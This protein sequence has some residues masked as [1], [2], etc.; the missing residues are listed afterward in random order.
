MRFPNS[1]VRAA[2]FASAILI[3]F[4]STAI[5]QDAVMKLVPGGE[6][7]RGRTHEWPDKDLPWYPNPLKDDTPVKRIRVDSFL[8]DEAE[9]SNARYAGFLAATQRKPPFHWIK[10][11]VAKGEENHPVVNVSWD[12]AAAFCAWD[13]KRLPT[14]AEW[15]HA[16]RGK[17]DDKK[18]PWGDEDP[19]EE[20]ARFGSQEGGPIAVCSKTRN[21]FELC[22]MIGNAWEWTSD[23]YG[24]EYYADAPAE[25]P[26]GPE[27][28]RYRVVRGGSWFDKTA[29]QFLTCS[30]RSWTRQTERSPNIG[31]RCVKA[32]PAE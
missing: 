21:D 28:G 2:L 15:E 18:Y 27:L 30:Y 19:S 11:H 10:G 9:V 23:W 8:M 12:D 29:S 3:A 31:F 4:V 17:Q 7:N 1:T 32:A 24:R 26:Q 22:D 16:C 13:G 14:E 20:Q 5:A 25:N 6:F